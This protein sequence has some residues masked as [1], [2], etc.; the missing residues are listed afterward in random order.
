[1]SASIVIVREKVI[2]SSGRE[3][4][5]AHVG[6]VALQTDKT[7]AAPRVR[8]TWGFIDRDRYQRATVRII[9]VLRCKPPRSLSLSLSLHSVQDHRDRRGDREP[10]V[11]RIDVPDVVIQLNRGLR[12]LD[13]SFAH[14][15]VGLDLGRRR[16]RRLAHRCESRYGGLLHRKLP[17]I[18]W[19]W[20][21]FSHG[22]ATK[23]CCCLLFCPVE[24][25][26]RTV[27]LVSMENVK[28]IK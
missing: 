21:Q 22:R 12:S 23:G 7:T 15:R 9:N 24:S 4:R 11:D 5:P 26:S 18:D 25:A 6:G 16:G 1:M 13:G 2:W 8:Y 14:H 20:G 19:H 28:K 10:L 3:G 27:I 17:L